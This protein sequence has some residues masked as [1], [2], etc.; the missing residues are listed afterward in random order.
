MSAVAECGLATAKMRAMT[1]RHRV[2]TDLR[3]RIADG[4]YLPGR[5]LPSEERL[6][7]EFGVSR[8]TVR[9]AV[10]E[11]RAAGQVEVYPGRGMLV[12]DPRARPPHTVAGGGSDHRWVGVGEP[13]SGTVPAPGE[14]AR[15]LALPPGT[16]VRYRQAVQQ[17]PL[18]STPL[19]F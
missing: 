18:T 16:R 15:L 11:L 8:P 19:G 9:A 7:R 10:A 14:V 5:M 6:A 12:R 17:A 4:T 13:E 3:D 2:A 1:S